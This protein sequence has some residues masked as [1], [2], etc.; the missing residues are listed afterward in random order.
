MLRGLKALYKLLAL[1][2]ITENWTTRRGNARFS[3]TQIA[4]Q[5][6][7][8]LNENIGFGVLVH[9]RGG[10]HNKRPQVPKKN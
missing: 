10:Q 5:R 4:I 8:I 7:Q 2:S 3:K 6:L 9:A 1:I